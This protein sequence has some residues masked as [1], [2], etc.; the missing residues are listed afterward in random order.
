MNA[1]FYE[2]FSSI[3]GEATHVGERHLFVRLAGC[4]L[5]CVFCDT[6]ASHRIPDDARLFL[7]ETTETLPNPLSRA[8]L[9]SWVQHLDEAAGPHHAIA[10][11]GGE[12]LLFVDFLIPLLARWDRFPILLETGGHLP[13]EL[14][15]LID[16]VDMVMMDVKLASSAGFVTDAETTTRFLETARKKEL[17]VKLVCSAR[18]TADEIEPVVRLLEDEPLILQPVSGATFHPPTGAHM[19]ALQR[20]AMRL[21]R[22]T[23]VIPQTHRQLHVR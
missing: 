23:R 19:L 15:R 13:Q 16:D 6:P 12:P 7:P 17:C 18:T 21:H 4:D 5:E 11:T 10:I 2:V 3:Q 8:Q 1:P 20:A 14:A 22:D 9:D